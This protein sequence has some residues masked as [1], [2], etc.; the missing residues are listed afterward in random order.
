MS[1]EPLTAEETGSAVAGPSLTPVLA[2]SAGDVEQ[3]VRLSRAG[4]AILSLRLRTAQQEADQ[5][6]AEVD[7]WDLDGAR[8]L[9]EVSLDERVA[10]RRAEMADELEETRRDAADTVAAARG[11]AAEMVAAASEETLELLLAGTGGRSAGAP[12]LRVVTDDGPPP[13]PSPAVPLGDH[14]AAAAR[15]VPAVVSPPALPAL[16]VLDEHPTS[17]A[18]PVVEP[19][20]EPTSDPEPSAPA[21]E[22]PPVAPQP[23]SVP[24]SAQVVPP[25]GYV[26]VDAASVAWGSSPGALALAQVTAPGAAA[27]GSEAG[28]ATPRW[29]QFLYVDVLLP[30]VAVLV[31]LTILLAWVG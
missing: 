22:E 15:A 24:A 2:A 10:R 19:D 14:P 3:L 29:R 23:S 17:V 6:S 7:E 26:L 1:A 25:P 13:R 30:M 31:V 28:R 27:V 11:D 5:V 20:P 8:L 21:L 18:D 4:I 9:L 12:S 16:P